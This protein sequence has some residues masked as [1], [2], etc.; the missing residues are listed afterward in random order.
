MLL[1]KQTCAHADRENIT[2]K[3]MPRIRTQTEKHTPLQTTKAIA[4]TS[5]HGMRAPAD[6][7]SARRSPPSFEPWRAQRDGLPGRSRGIFRTKQPLT[8]SPT[9][10]AVEQDRRGAA[11]TRRAAFVAT[12]NRRRQRADT[13]IP[14]CRQGQGPPA[15]A[16]RRA[17]ARLVACAKAPAALLRPA[18]HAHSGS[19]CAPRSENKTHPSQR[20][21]THEQ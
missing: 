13:S 16:S 18:P 11:F 5:V 3:S 7:R 15:S 4:L 8:R 19:A 12:R 2:Q 17:V 20:S 9:S 21:W 6:A 14:A 1:Q 10:C